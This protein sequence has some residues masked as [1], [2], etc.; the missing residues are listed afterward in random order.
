M[1]SLFKSV[2][3]SLR[4]RLHSL[5]TAEQKSRIK[6]SVNYKLLNNHSNTHNR[7]LL[8]V[9]EGVEGFACDVQCCESWAF[10]L[11][12]APSGKRCLQS[13][14]PVTHYAQG[15]ALHW[16]HL[17]TLR[18]RTVRIW[19]RDYRTSNKLDHVHIKR[20]VISLWSCDYTYKH[21]IRMKDMHV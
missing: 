15:L 20:Q 6:I 2:Y 12:C 4:L 1:P 18:T 5:P 13:R 11:C 17:T 21:F 3:A 9:G 19:L 16:D 7:M 14:G 8:T 10:G